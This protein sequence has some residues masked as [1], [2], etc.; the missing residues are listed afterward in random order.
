[1]PSVIMF[2]KLGAWDIIDASIYHPRATWWCGV[3]NFK[4]AVRSMK[5]D[6]FFGTN[7]PVFRRNSK[8]APNQWVTYSQDFHF[9]WKLTIIPNM[10]FPPRRTSKVM[11]SDPFGWIEGWSCPWKL[12]WLNKKCC[13]EV[14]RIRE[15]TL[16]SP[17]LISFFWKKWH[18]NPDDWE[19]GT[20]KH[21]PFDAQ[22]EMGTFRLIYKENRDSENGIPWLWRRWWLG[23]VIP[24]PHQKARCF[25]IF[26]PLIKR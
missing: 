8:F 26:F 12:V 17:L 11:N 5:G 25:S 23:M 4:N 20:L 22:G 10:R 7:L 2:K 18:G 19:I 21:S 9:Y 1:M 24:F 3:W 16:K 6:N 15:I 14:L 13:F